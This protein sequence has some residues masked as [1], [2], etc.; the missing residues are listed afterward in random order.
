[1]ATVWAQI[2]VLQQHLRGMTFAQIQQ[3]IS[4]IERQILTIVRPELTSNGPAPGVIDSSA[5]AAAT[6]GPTPAGSTAPSSVETPSGATGSAP[7]ASP[8]PSASD[9]GQPSPSQSPTAS[10]SPS[11]SST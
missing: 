2:A 7:D 1:L 11:A 9:T 4:S 6:G 8:S 5:S 10:P 3:A